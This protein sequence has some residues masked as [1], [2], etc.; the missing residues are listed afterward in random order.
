MR[1][2]SIFLL[3]LALVS[4]ETK[5][6]LVDTWELVADQEIDSVGNVVR[7]D[8]NVNGMLIYTAKGEMSVQLVWSGKRD[9]MMTDSVMLHDGQSTGLGLGTNT[10]SSE[11]NRL[12]ID[13]YDAYF[14]E[15]EL[16][17]DNIVIH[18]LTANLRPEKQRTEFK[19]RY[20]LKGDTLFLRSADPAYRW[21]TIWQ[22]KQ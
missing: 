16:A 18:R 7:E 12:L 10:W 20:I 14:G 6:N 17:E 4:C 8:R 1:S 5:S 22:R 9:G 13:T 11:E 21:Q 19:R 2:I 3:A 15:Y